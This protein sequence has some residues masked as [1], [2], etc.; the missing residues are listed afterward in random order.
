M[1]L[2]RRLP[3]YTLALL[4]LLIL[5]FRHVPITRQFGDASDGTWIAVTGIALF[6]VSAL[7]MLTLVSKKVRT[8]LVPHGFGLIYK[9]ALFFIASY[10]IYVGYL[11]FMLY[12]G[13]AI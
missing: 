5:A 13:G 11:L 12:S 4:A 1:T 7:F 2:N 3:V 6:Y 10:T 9:A 8:F